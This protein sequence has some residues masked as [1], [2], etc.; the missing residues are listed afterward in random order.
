MWKPGGGARGIASSAREESL[1]ES[2]FSRFTFH[3]ILGGRV[4]RKMKLTENKEIEENGRVQTVSYASAGL[5][6]RFHLLL[7]FLLT[8]ALVNQV[9][10]IPLN[11]WGN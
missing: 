11:K 8:A 4:E 3:L 2:R 5:L 7:S 9:S 1:T 6:G 10:L